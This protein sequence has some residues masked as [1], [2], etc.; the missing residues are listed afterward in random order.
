MLR[1]C[2][3]TIISGPDVQKL[4]GGKMSTQ[5]QISFGDDNGGLEIG[6]SNGDVHFHQNLMPGDYL[7]ELRA[8]ML[9]ADFC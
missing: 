9:D 6:I 5:H 1:F 7:Y 2:A 3:L 8:P 4:R